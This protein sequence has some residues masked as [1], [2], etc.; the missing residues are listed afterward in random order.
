MLIGVEYVF[1]AYGIWVCTFAVYVLMIK[2]RMRIADK[3]LKAIK[4]RD[5][6]S[7][8]TFG[9]TVSIGNQD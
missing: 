4:Q 5:P 6:E 7:S 1:A 8:V 3:T 9:K 2:R